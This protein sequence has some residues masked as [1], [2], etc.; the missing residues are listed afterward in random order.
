ML[1]FVYTHMRLAHEVFS[2]HVGSFFVVT[3]SAR[4]THLFFNTSLQTTTS[5]KLSSS[6]PKKH[7]LPSVDLLFPARGIIMCSRCGKL[8]VSSN[9]IILQSNVF[10]IGDNNTWTIR[11]DK[12]VFYVVRR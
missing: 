8:V 1:R 3:T 11:T 9:G 4:D 7:D 6:R 5:S 2:A 10:V 12:T